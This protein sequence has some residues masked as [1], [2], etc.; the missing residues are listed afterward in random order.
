MGIAFARERGFKGGISDF[1]PFATQISLSCESVDFRDTML[2]K[3]IRLYSRAC[4]IKQAKKKV[5]KKMKRLTSLGLVVLCIISLVGCSQAEGPGESLE[6]GMEAL[7]ADNESGIEKYFGTHP[8]DDD[9]IRISSNEEMM[10]VCN[11]AIC[12]H[13]TY[14]ITNVEENED[15]KTAEATVLITSID[16]PGV[17]SQF[18]NY[19]LNYETTYYEMD[20]DERPTAEEINTAHKEKFLK[21]VDETTET[22]QKSATFAMTKQKNYWTISVNAELRD[23]ISG[24]L[25]SLSRN[26]ENVAESFAEDD[27]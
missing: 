27:K 23:A 19:M 9:E 1:I 8:L 15:G 2:H 21:L 11:Q 7:I 18:I 22:T 4:S 12:S 3:M 13:L 10:K 17:M 26:L 16:M 14:Q 24:G 5:S 20:E 6:K 25:V